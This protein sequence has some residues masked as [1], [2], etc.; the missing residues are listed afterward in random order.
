M[1]PLAF[2][3]DPELAWVLICYLMNKYDAT[4]PHI[5]FSIL[6]EFVL[7]KEYFIVTSN[8][9]EHFQKAGFNKNRIFEYHDSMY[10]TQCMYNIECGV[11]DTPY[12]KVDA[13]NIIASRIPVCPECNSY[14][15]PN[16]YLF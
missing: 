10:N 12:L 16:V 2:K 13:E 11:W 9:D 7:Q 6:K 14:C 4:P 1:T 5:G 15:R 8:I 3:A